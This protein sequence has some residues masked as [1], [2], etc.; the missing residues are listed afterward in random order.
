MARGD[1]MH[2][3]IVGRHLGSAIFQLIAKSYRP[4]SDGQRGLGQ[5]GEPLAELR[6]GADPGAPETLPGVGVGGGEGL[7]AAS[8]EDGET[9]APG[10]RAGESAGERV[11]GADPGQRQPGAGAEPPGAGDPDPQAG[12]RAGTDADRDPL[13]CAPAAR[14]LGR[15]LD[16]LE[17]ARGVPRAAIGR[18]AEQGLVEN[19]AAAGRADGGV[20]GSRVEADQRQVRSRSAPGQLGTTKA[21]DP[22]FLP[23]T[24]QLTTCLPGMFDVILFT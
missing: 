21:K 11:E 16:L 1:P 9:G 19:L 4:R 10:C 20:L 17:E 24:N 5:L 14:G 3:I 22:T 2:G 13:D 8:V 6:R 12:E 18:E 15:P 23:S 7:A